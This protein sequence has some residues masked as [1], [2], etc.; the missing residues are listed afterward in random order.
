MNKKRVGILFGGMSCEH[1]VSLLSA[2][3]VLENID[4]EKYSPI[5]I[6]ITKEGKWYLFE[7]DISL[8]KSGEWEKC[9]N[10]EVLI[11]PSRGTPLYAVKDGKLSEFNLD[12]IFPVLHG[13]YCEDGRLQGLL[14]SAGIPFVGPGSL[15]SAICMDKAMTKLVLKNYGI[16]QAKALLVTKRE[17]ISG[18]D[19]IENS[20]MLLSYPLFVKPSAAGS[21]VGVSKAENSSELKIAI[22]EALAVG[23]RVLVEEYIEGA[24]I[25]VAILGNDDLTVSVCGEIAPGSDFYDYDTKYKNDTAK[26]YIPARLDDSVSEKIRD[27]A[28]RIFRALD[29]KGLS[30][31]DF[32]VNGERIIFNEINTLPGFTSISMYPKL[33][34]ASGMSYS[35]LITNL[36]E[37]SLENK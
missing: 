27:Y 29:C 1:E 11:T 19:K 13:S 3:S 6:G 30:R 28:S 9:D 16:P 18:F 35:D 25:E 34:M 24:E 8:I 17:F 7:G 22:E 33:M 14:E 12:A 5:P 2:T 26:Y 10:A 15:S 36:I 4:R 20:A 23:D 32:F 37:L 21:S 31:V